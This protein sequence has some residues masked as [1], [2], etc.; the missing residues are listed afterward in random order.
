M[1][2]N[3]TNTLE[4]RASH[5]RLHMAKTSCHTHGTH[6]PNILVGA[7]HQRRNEL[8]HSWNSL[9]EHL[10]GRMASGGVRE[11]SRFQQ[12]HEFLPALLHGGLLDVLPKGRPRSGWFVALPSCVLAFSPPYPFMRCDTGHIDSLLHEAVLL[13]LRH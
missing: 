2:K 9:A 4:R 5:E 7:W 11:M 8:P 13:L 6:S 3:K 10:G 1:T 12:L